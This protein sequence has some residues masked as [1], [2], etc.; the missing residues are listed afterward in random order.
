[1]AEYS[2]I[3]VSGMHRSGTSLLASYLQNCGLELGQ[4]LLSGDRN[5]TKGY[6]EQNAVLAFQREVLQR[7][8]E[9]DKARFPDWGITLGNDSLSIG[10]EHVEGANKLIEELQGQGAVAW[11]EPRSVMLFEL[12]Q[13]VIPSAKWLLIYREPWEVLSSIERLDEK[14][15]QDDPGLAREAWLRYNQQVL[16]IKQEKGDDCI[17]IGTR[18]LLTDGA[19]IVEEVNRR[20][21]T[22]LQAKEIDHLFDG[23]LMDRT[24]NAQ[25]FEASMGHEAVLATLKA[26]DKAADLPNNPTAI[27]DVSVVITCYNDGQYLKEALYSVRRS[28][29]EVPV[30]IV[31]DGSTDEGTLTVLE[32]L[33]EAGV[34]VLDQ[35][36]KG[37]PAAR[38]V[39]F[40]AVTTEYVLPLDA[41]NRI[42]PSYL[43]LAVD[44]LN[45]TPE[46]AFAYADRRTFGGTPKLKRVGEVSDLAMLVGNHIDACAVIRKSAWEEVG[47]YCE[48]LRDGYE[49]WDLWLSFQKRYSRVHLP[50]PLFDYR[51]REGSLL[52]KMDD[53]ELRRRTVQAITKRHAE[54][55]EE[56]AKDIVADLHAIQAHGRALRSAQAERHAEE[57]R[58]LQMQVAAGRADLEAIQQQLAEAEA[59]YSELQKSH[60]ASKV[61]LESLQQ[62]HVALQRHEAEVVKKHGVLLKRHEELEQQQEKATAHNEELSAEAF[63]LVQEMEKSAKELER[64]RHYALGLSEQVKHLGLRLKEMEGTRLWRFRVQYHKM[65]NMLRSA[66]GRTSKGFRWLRKLVFFLS[67][68]GRNLLRKVF[69]RI[70][71]ALYLLFEVQSVRIVV[72]GETVEQGPDMAVAH[73]DPYYTWMA[74]NMPRESDLSEYAERIPEFKLQPKFSIVMPVYNPPIE[75]FKQAIRSVQDQI[76][77]NWELCLADDLSSDPA[78]RQTIEEL[79][80]E[81]ERIK[82]VF[83]TENGHISAASNS[84]LELVSGEFVVLMDHDD[85][86]TKDALYQN[87]K[88][89]NKQPKLDLIYS[90]EDKVDEQQHFSEPHFKPQWCPDHLLSRNYFGHLVVLRS[91]I[92]KEIG[93]FR[94][95][96]EGSQDYDLMLRFT[97]RTERIAHIPK[98]LYRWRIHSGSA[99]QSE[100][101]KPYAYDAAKRALTEALERRGEPAKVDF[102]PGFRGYDIRF[103]M[104]SPPKVSIVIPTKDKEEVLRV[105]LT[106]I[107]EKTE[108]PDFEVCVVSNNS[109]E[110]QT[111]NLLKHYE[112]VED[113]RFKWFELNDD[114]NFSALMNAAVAKTDGAHVL[115][116]NND[117][118]VIHADW[119]TAMVEQSQRASI[120]AVGAKLLYPNDTI[121]H[122]GVLIGLG[123]AAGH[124]FVG[125]H[126]D[127][128]GYFNYINTINNYSAVTA[129]CMMVERNKLEAVGGFDEALAVEYNDVDLCLR[130]RESG[131]NNI[132]LPHVSMYHHESLSRG[133]PHLTKESYERHIREIGI[134]QSRWKEYIDDDPCYNPNLSRGV[135]DFQF[136][137]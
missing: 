82:C 21:G 50:F 44:A 115:F 100:E 58:D 1:M 63:R 9:V 28:L 81:D 126:K 91:S 112:K 32:E 79:M 116:L 106:S 68:K 51:E 46:A 10:K 31:N 137:L 105:C 16:Q 30:M 135:H 131:L 122:A 111:F 120:G 87:L 39:G 11:K 22:A 97:E 54:A 25:Y 128:P 98:V 59:S 4:D 36:N 103:E 99:A 64:Q 119:I 71:K 12:W 93:G 49:D 43:Q 27:S 6:F 33:R 84:A 62:E 52:G 7:V 72:Q 34:N 23:A 38:N 127:G 77:D 60:K 76:Y 35:E 40:D 24:I 125:Y 45:A 121:Q 56:H 5:N 66:S 47:K 37:L 95:G 74:R 14:V 90:D 41:D 29:L 110:D 94:E 123:G 108:Y 86:I 18:A 124:T 19:R 61:Q 78:V 70:F 2:P 42:D 20:W 73:Q 96:F 15:F 75:F 17:L 117:T 109:S 67:R 55:Y 65:R 113:Q 102:L 8:V 26:L 104:K 130:L 53:P 48:S 118:E 132:Y 3:I 136:A 88:L 83:R 114:F 134:F 129:A 101:V 69:A 92:M 80:L 57:L 85:L 133:H 89:L 107:F 13:K